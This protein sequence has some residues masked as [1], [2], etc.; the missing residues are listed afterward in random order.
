MTTYLAARSD[1]HLGT[2][3][4]AVARAKSEGGLRQYCAAWYA[5]GSRV[6]CGRR[7]IPQV[8]ETY[9]V[10]GVATAGSW[11][12]E[13]GVNEHA[14]AVSWEPIATREPAE[15]NPG[16]SG[17]DLV[18][19]A[20]ERGRNAR[21]ALEVLAALIERFG[22]SHGAGL[23]PNDHRFLFAD[24]GEAWCLECAGRRWAAR[25]VTR[26]LP[27]ETL[28]VPEIGRD[29]EIGSKGLEA[30]ARERHWCEGPKRLDFAVVYGEHDSAAH[31]DEDRAASPVGR[32]DLETR[33]RDTG[34]GAGSVCASLPHDRRRPW[35][36][37]VSAGPAPVGVFLPVYL[38]AI[39][40]VEALVQDTG[41]FAA[42][43]EGVGRNFELS[44]PRVRDAWKGFE[45]TL[46]R[47]RR[48][49]ERQV[50]ELFAAERDPE[51][52]DRLSKWSAAL[53]SRAAARAAELVSTLE[54]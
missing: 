21:E 5:P 34:A 54:L 45:A 1:A 28:P 27:T 46:E 32:D 31:P 49:V 30:Y 51:G 20:L 4:I 44:Q 29:W 25:R 17:Q 36:L 7:E 15:A 16:L 52:R 18:R 47:E 24:P 42:L 48:V 2:T 43:A 40:P 26:R 11:G 8:G 14:V 33:L 10:V 12:L 19:L 6:R 35:P 41:A 37:W 13:C 53:W 38:D 9:G 50:A 22:A 39:L 3:Q 23:A